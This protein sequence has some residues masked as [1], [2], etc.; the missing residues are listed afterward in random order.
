MFKGVRY[1]SALVALA[2]VSAWTIAATQVAFASTKTANVTLPV[3]TKTIH[4]MS[5]NVKRQGTLA[6]VAGVFVY[7]SAF[8][9]PGGPVT[10]GY[11]T[12]NASGNWTIPKLV[13]GQ[14]RVYYSA[15]SDANLLFSYW[16]ATG[17]NYNNLSTASAVTI[18]TA[19]KTGV[20]TRLQVGQTIAGKITKIDGTTGIPDVNVS[21]YG[22]GSGS[23][24][25]DASGNYLI[26]GLRPGSYTIQVN[27]QE[28]DPYQGGC[29]WTGAP[30]YKFSSNCASHTALTVAPNKTGINIRL[31]GAFMITGF[32]KNRSNVAIP[33]ADISADQ[34]SPNQ[35]YDS[36]SAQTD[37][38]GKFVLKGLNPGQY[39][40]A[41]SALRHDATSTASTTRPMRRTA[42]RW[43]IPVR[44]MSSSRRTSPSR[45][46]SDPRPASA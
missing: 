25:T 42:G 41:E 2:I 27:P 3:T 17:P 4:S 43:S 21:A 1:R 14:Y 15:P 23:A 26:K 45:A 16:N 5:G 46:R 31:P 37:G 30:L 22:P 44:R 20:N 28:E 18:G 13:S 24:Q 32:L 9:Y 10:S 29:Y 6:N 33:F 38:T 34:V 36:S 35:W 7:A 40:I 11:A 19:N 12:T 8:T 39:Q